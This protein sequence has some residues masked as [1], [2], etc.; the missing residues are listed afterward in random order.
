[1]AREIQYLYLHLAQ[2]R[3]SGESALGKS[4]HTP[5]VNEFIKENNRLLDYILGNYSEATWLKNVDFF[6]NL[7]SFVNECH[8]FIVTSTTDDVRSEIFTCLR[9]VLKEWIPD[10][11]KYVII[12]SHGDFGYKSFD[13]GKEDVF[14][15]IESTLSFVYSMRMIP[16]Y[17][18]FH[19]KADF[20]DNAALYHEVGHFVDRYHNVTG[21]LIEDVKK[22]T[23]AIPQED[24]YLNDMTETLANDPGK[25][26]EQLADYIS[27]FIA[28]LFAARYTRD[29]IFH[30]LSYINPTGTASKRHPSHNARRKVVDEFLGNPKD[31]SNFLKMLLQYIKNESTHELTPLPHN[32]DITSFVQLKECNKPSSPEHVHSIVPNLWELWNNRRGDFK[33]PDSTQMH[34]IDV[35]KTLMD[36]TA[37]AV[38][39]LQ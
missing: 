7:L 18:P 13:W 22:G 39:K 38:Q 11:E 9:F 14:D 12:C 35:Y 29:S 33:N 17:M 28:D 21:L 31:Y 37:K 34:F 26:Y 10:P 27:E 6:Y 2:L 4:Y 15:H 8:A 3:L 5:K 24:V 32:T 20:M 30:F 23:L 1:M 16:I 19:M 36:L 25:Y